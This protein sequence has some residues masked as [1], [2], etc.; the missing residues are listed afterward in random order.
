[1]EQRLKGPQANVFVGTPTW[2]NYEPLFKHAGFADHFTAYAFLDSYGNIDMNNILETLE[3]APKQS[4]FVFQ[5][6]CHNPTGRDLSQ[7]QWADIATVVRERDHFAFFDTAYQG[8]GDGTS[9]DAWAVRHFADMGINMLVCQSFSKNAGLYSERVGAL[10]VVCQRREISKNVLDTLRSVV[11]WEVSSAP[12]YG[13]ELVNS[14][15]ECP[16]AKRQWLSELKDARNRI[17]SL[18]IDLHKH[19]TERLRTPSPRDGEVR[20]WDHIVQETGLFSFTGLTAVQTRALIDR[21][22][23]YLPSNGRINVSGL[24]QGNILRVANAIDDVVRSQ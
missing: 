20:G 11:R 8:L 16:E 18:R 17:H 14:I 10:H 22:H 2:G 1:M 24:S 23:I 12:A 15:L 9:E 7:E 21:H 5:G 13:A 4:I 19:L 6:C 3:S